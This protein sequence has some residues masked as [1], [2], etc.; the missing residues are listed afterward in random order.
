MTSYYISKQNII[1]LGYKWLSPSKTSNYFQY[2]N[3]RRYGDTY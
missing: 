2:K 3:S 1:S